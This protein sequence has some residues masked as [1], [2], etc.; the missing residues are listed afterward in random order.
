MK[1]PENMSHNNW[2]KELRCLTHRREEAVKYN[3]LQ[4][5]ELLPHGRENRLVVI[6]KETR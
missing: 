3:S 4:I 6:A 5:L 2:L 1:E